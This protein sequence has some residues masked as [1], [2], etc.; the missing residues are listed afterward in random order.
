MVKFFVFLW[1][2]LHRTVLPRALKGVR[3]QQ[4]G[5]ARNLTEG[6]RWCSLLPRLQGKMGGGVSTHPPP[7]APVSAAPRP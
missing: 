2:A 1:A 6:V 7:P 5:A 3:V 4:A